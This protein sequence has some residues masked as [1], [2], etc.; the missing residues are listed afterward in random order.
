L[1]I[2][3][4]VQLRA[5]SGEPPTGFTGLVTRAAFLGWVA[6]SKPALSTLLHGGYDPSKRRRSFYSIK[7]LRRNPSGGHTFSVV[8]LEDALAQEAL[9]AILQSQHTTLRMG[10]ATFEATAINIKQVDPQAVGRRLCGH[11]PYDI[12]FRTPT[13]FSVKGS[14]FK[15][16]QPNLTLLLTNVANTLH[17]GK[18]ESI[19]R[20][21]IRALRPKLGIT[22]LEVKSVITRNGTRVYPG[23]WGWVRVTSKGLDAEEERLL[24]RL[25]EWAELFNVG[26]GRTAGFG[27]V[28]ISPVAKQREPGAPTGPMQT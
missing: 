6:A 15:V 21:K 25:A 17:I 11:A 19:P 23:F 14:P 28:E 1:M 22:G 24:A 9:E 18:I 26:G 10:E 7:P 12:R 3:V 5:V 8:F 2:E 16:I 27:V 20:E 13:Y 4:I